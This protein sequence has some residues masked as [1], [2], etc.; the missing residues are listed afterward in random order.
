[1][2]CVVTADEKAGKDRLEIDNMFLVGSRRTR[3][4]LKDSF[5]S[6]AHMIGLRVDDVN[7]SDMVFENVNLSGTSF[8]DVNMSGAKIDF[9]NLSGLAITNAN[10]T[11]MTIDGIKVSDLIALWDTHNGNG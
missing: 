7:A 6:D 5:I 10:I 4:S 8:H 3:V 2:D 9:A 1:M 11:D